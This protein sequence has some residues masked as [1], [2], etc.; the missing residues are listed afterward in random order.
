VPTRIP[1]EFVVR[2]TTRDKNGN[3]IG[4]QELI[5]YQGL[6][7]L[8]HE[9]GLKGIETTLIQAPNAANGQ[10]AIVRAAAQGTTGTFT[11]IGDASPANVTARVA[12]HVLRVAETRAKARALR[13]LTNVAMV[14]LEEVGELDEEQEPPP[15][16]A[17]DRGGDGP[18]TDQQRREL[19]T[20][21]A[22]LGLDRVR[23]DQALM[24]RH[25]TDLAHISRGLARRVTAQLSR[26]A[27]GRRAAE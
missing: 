26:E 19:V 25:G 21:A 16:A 3:P 2:V 8:A 17:S 5:T 22:T 18:A 10:M 13:D 4:Q 14:A 9:Q 27:A 6:L 23:L 15:R 7:A 11:G 1:P 20:K 24:Q 12:R